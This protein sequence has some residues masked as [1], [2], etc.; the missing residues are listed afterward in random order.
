MMPFSIFNKAGA[1]LVTEA[2]VRTLQRCAAMVIP[3]R[4]EP[5]EPWMSLDVRAMIAARLLRDRGL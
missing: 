1:V 5:P 3:W 4:G 2:D